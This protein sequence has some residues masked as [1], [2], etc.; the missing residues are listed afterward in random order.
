MI[1]LNRGREVFTGRTRHL[2]ASKLIRASMKMLPK[3]YEVMST[4]TVDDLA[5]EAMRTIYQA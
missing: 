3:K 4:C 2:C 5:G 1:L